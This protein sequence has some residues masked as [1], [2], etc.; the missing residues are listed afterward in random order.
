MDISET[1]S[2]PNDTLPK[3]TLPAYRLRLIDDS[4]NGFPKV[5]SV[6]VEPSQMAVYKT[7]LAPRLTQ[8]AS[9]VR[10]KDVA[11]RAARIRFPGFLTQLTYRSLFIR[12]P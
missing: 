1:S 12:M 9:F 2:L 10:I 3:R 6:R 4:H 8:V 11:P 5:P 7:R